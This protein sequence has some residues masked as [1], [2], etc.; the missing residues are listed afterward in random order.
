M[1]E[2]EGEEPDLSW[3]PDPDKK[4]DSDADDSQ[5]S[6]DDGPIVSRK[7]KLRSTQ[8]DEEMVLKLM[9]F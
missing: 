7:R 3:L 2:S 5:D 9:K 6:A 8:N 1:G 4:Y